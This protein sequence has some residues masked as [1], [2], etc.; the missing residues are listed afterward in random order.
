MPKCS[1]TLLKTPR[2]QDYNIVEIGGGHYHHFGLEQQ[3]LKL[4]ELLTFSTETESAEIILNVDGLPIS[5][6][7]KSQ[8][9]PILGMVNNSQTYRKPFLIGLYYG[10]SSKPKDSNE[11]LK[12]LVIELQSVQDRFIEI[13]LYRLK[14]NVTAF[15]CD[16]PARS[17]L[18]RCVPHNSYYACERCEVKGKYLGRVVYSDLNERGRTD[19][20]FLSQK[21]I[22]H[23]NGT[24]E[25][26]LAGMGL[27]S[28]FLLD[29]MH[30]VC[31]G[32]VR[33]LLVTWR[34]GPLPHREGSQFVLRVSERLISLRPHIPSNF[35]RKPRSFLELDFW[36]AT[37][38]RLF[39]LYVGP[40]VLRGIL[41]SEKYNHFL[42]LSIAIRIL[43]S[44]NRNFYNYARELLRVFVSNTIVLY[45]EEFLTYNLHSL[46]HLADDALKFGSLEK[47]NSFPFENFMQTIKSM[48]RSKNHHLAQIVRRISERD[49]VAMKPLHQINYKLRLCKNSAG[50]IYQLGQDVVI[51]SD[52]TDSGAVVIKFLA[53]RDFFSHPCASS[54]FGIYRVSN[55]SKRSILVQETNLLQKAMLLP[56]F[57]ETN[58]DEYACLPLSENFI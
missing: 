35:N 15:A 12:P 10:N 55:P 9:W 57:G 22:G 38:F 45:S 42:T 16:A 49:F 26:A 36:K 31:L 21:Q 46:L 2:S 48:L 39:L 18:K 7:S 41:S 3:L 52:L 58:G 32:V 53:K 51:L 54:T 27:V 47:I 56:I 30:L 25:L 50:N 17:F 37:E 14:V 4:G 29:Y 33:K 34:R 8:L 1:K 28:D 43:L 20:D 24:S 6:S 19:S 5:R 40:V 11:F 13:G 23:H 44:N